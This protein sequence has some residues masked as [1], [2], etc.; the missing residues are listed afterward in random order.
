MYEYEFVV[1]AN[2]EH[3]EALLRSTLDAEQRRVVEGLLWA[4]RA[5]LEAMEP[6]APPPSTRTM[7]AEKRTPG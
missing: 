4:E 7:I 6:P 1:R 3:F 5:K 2:I